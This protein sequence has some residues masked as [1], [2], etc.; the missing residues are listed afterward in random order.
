LA[1][2]SSLDDKIIAAGS[3]PKNRNFSLFVAEDISKFKGKPFLKPGYGPITY[4]D[5]KA[6]FVGV[7]S[8]VP[9]TGKLAKQYAEWPTKAEYEQA[10]EQTYPNRLSIAHGKAKVEEGEEGFILH[11]ISTTKSSSGSPIV[12]DEG[13]VFG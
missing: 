1:N 4:D 3:F 7:N 11:N 13:R 12:D 6:W 10:V 2:F 9:Y 8:A 5:V